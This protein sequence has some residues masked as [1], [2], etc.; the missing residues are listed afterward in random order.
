MIASI[1]ESKA[2]LSEFVALANDG[3]EVIITVRGKPSAKLVPFETSENNINTKEWVEE[4]KARLSR[5]QPPGPSTSSQEI[6]N[7]LREERF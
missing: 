7:Q 3:E 4:I 5:Q 2:R 6:L 1:R